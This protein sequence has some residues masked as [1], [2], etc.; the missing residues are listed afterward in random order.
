MFAPFMRLMDL[1]IAPNDMFA[2]LWGS[3][4]FG[5]RVKRC[6]RQSINCQCVERHVRPFCEAHGSLCRVKDMFAPKKAHGSLWNAM[7]Q[8]KGQIVDVL[9]TCLPLKRLMDLIPRE[10]LPQTVN[11]L[12]MWRRHA[13]LLG[14]SWIFEFQKNFILPQPSSI[15]LPISLN[16]KIFPT[17]P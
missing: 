4:I 12:P 1:Y 3:W 11:L 2:P 16:S 15:W 10:A 5:S 17:T 8:T 14:G 7:P 6:H 9:K 13:C